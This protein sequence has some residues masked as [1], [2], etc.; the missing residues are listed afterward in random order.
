MQHLP[1]TRL[2]LTPTAKP[3]ET[4]GGPRHKR[5]NTGLR[6]LQCTRELQPPALLGRGLARPMDE[7]NATSV[8]P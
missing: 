8:G 6:C 3:G 4:F 1:L 5:M 7:L 2:K